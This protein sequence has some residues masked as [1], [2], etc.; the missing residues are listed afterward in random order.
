MGNMTPLWIFMDLEKL[1]N[2]L[3]G[4][5]FGQGLILRTLFLILEKP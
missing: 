5:Q 4:A 2:G 1:S 3:R